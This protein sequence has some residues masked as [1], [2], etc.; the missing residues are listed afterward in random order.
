MQALPKRFTEVWTPADC[1]PYICTTC[2]NEI[3]VIGD[4]ENEPVKCLS[5][6]KDGVSNCEGTE[7]TGG[8]VFF[9]LEP[10]RP[11]IQMNIASKAI[12]RVP[13][14]V[15]G[16]SVPDEVLTTA[17]TTATDLVRFTLKK[18][19]GLMDPDR[20]GEEFGLVFDE[21]ELFGKTLFVLT[22][23]CMQR[24]PAILYAELVVKARYLGGQTEE[25]RINAGFTV[26]SSDSDSTG[27]KGAEAPGKT[28]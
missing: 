15:E 19:K 10:L 7:F 27:V 1:D 4:G 3:P 11:N 20:P 2:G 8:E 18:I 22:Q 14:A 21:I 13:E 25:E 23:E 17:A 16:Q 24:I 5:V 28:N 26:S 12:A 6:D 9:V